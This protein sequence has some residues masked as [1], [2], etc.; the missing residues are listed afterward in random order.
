VPVIFTE[1]TS[2]ET[3]TSS[4]TLPTTTIKGKLENYFCFLRADVTSKIPLNL[5]FKANQQQPPPLRRSKIWFLPVQHR[6]PRRP[7]PQ[8]R[9]QQQ[10]QRQPQRQLQPPLRQLRLPKHALK[11]KVS[12][13]I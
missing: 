4:S 9:R 1:P 2:S 10:Q 7:R 13:E 11:I 6:V 12:K 3:S 5:N 8:R